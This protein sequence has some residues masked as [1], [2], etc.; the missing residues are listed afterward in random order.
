[1]QYAPQLLFSK[2][3]CPPQEL[4]KAAAVRGDFGGALNASRFLVFLDIKRQLMYTT[5]YVA[6]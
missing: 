2:A 3:R 1:M 5:V 4:I 6:V